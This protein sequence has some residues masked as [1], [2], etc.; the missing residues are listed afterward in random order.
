MPVKTFHV[1]ILWCNDISL[2]YGRDKGWTRFW[3]GQKDAWRFYVCVVSEIYLYV[4][5]HAFNE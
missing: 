4:Q 3:Y 5:V 2:I 1:I